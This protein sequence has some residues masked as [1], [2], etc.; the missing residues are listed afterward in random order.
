MKVTSIEIHPSGSSEVV[1]LSFRDPRRLNPFNVTSIVGL[2]ADEIVPRFYGV[3]GDKKYYSLSME[4]RQ[5]VFKIDLNPSFSDQSYSDLRDQLYRSI[6]SSRTGVVDIQ[7]KNGTEVVAVLSGFVSK[8]ENDLF[9]ENPNVTLTIDTIEPILKAPTR[10]SLDILTL[11]A[12]STHILDSKSTMPH[13]FI[14]EMGFL[15]AQASLVITPPDDAWAFTITP[16]GGFLL[17]DIIHFSSELNNK[18]LY[19]HRAGVDIHLADVIGT[20]PIWPIL[21]PGDNVL[22]F[23]NP[24]NLVWESVAFYPTYWGV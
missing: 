23:S 4:K 1:I 15:G 12:A 10:T 8:L 3:S 22:E 16:V 2:D 5:P 21:F 20:N 14:F 9:A 11:D 24:T 7:F 6:A 13:G 19:V 18:Y 17:G